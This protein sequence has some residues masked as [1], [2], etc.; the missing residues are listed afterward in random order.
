MV[1]PR[2]A[3]VLLADDEETVRNY[4]RR[5]LADQGL[6]VAVAHNGR[7]AV[8]IF[9]QRHE[10]IDCVLLDFR[11]PGMDGETTFQELRRVSTDV[12]VIL[13]AGCLEGDALIRMMSAGLVGCMQK[14]VSAERLV[15]E[16]W[17]VVGM[18]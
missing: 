14:P 6:Q 7:E 1:V 10:T 2:K 12:P 15:G 3:C 5:V 9:R 11:M 13:L 16:V 17:R 18:E 4:F 8:E